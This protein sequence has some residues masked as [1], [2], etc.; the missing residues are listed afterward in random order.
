MGRVGS[1]TRVPMRQPHNLRHDQGEEVAQSRSNAYSSA[2][3]SKGCLAVGTRTTRWLI[4]A[5]WLDELH[6]SSFWGGREGV[7]GPL[8]GR[9]GSVRQRKVIASGHFESRHHHTKK[10]SYIYRFGFHGYFWVSRRLQRQTQHSTSCSKHHCTETIHTLTK[11]NTA[12][13]AHNTLCLAIRSHAQ[14]RRF[15]QHDKLFQQ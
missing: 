14:P 15:P 2:S 4:H 8:Q 5:R 13:N 1:K 9:S 3:S 10:I 7:V 11:F 12:L 6:R